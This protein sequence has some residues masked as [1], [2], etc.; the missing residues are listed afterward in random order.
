[1]IVYHLSFAEG[2]VVVE[3]LLLVVVLL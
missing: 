1:M 2:Q 3:L